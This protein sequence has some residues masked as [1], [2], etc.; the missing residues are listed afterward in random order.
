MAIRELIAVN[1]GVYPAR[2]TLL[3]I[4]ELGALSTIASGDDLGH[5]AATTDRPGGRQSR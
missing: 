1:T 4:D 3:A 2:L 5:L